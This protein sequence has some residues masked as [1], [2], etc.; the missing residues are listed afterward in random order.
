MGNGTPTM[1]EADWR[2]GELSHLQGGSHLEY[3]RERQWPPQ[4]R[5]SQRLIA[6]LSPL[7]GDKDRG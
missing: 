2:C 4:K 7:G 5:L 3:R 6:R 1:Q